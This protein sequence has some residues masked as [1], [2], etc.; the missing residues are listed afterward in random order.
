MLFRSIKTPLQHQET[1]RKKK[2]EKSPA[3]S[4]Q[5]ENQIHHP[6]NQLFHTSGILEISSFLP[7]SC[8][9]NIKNKARKLKE[10]SLTRIKKKHSALQVGRVCESDPPNCGKKIIARNKKRILK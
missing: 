5:H 9:S 7:E 1:D 6:R 2:L 4:P 8:K 3:R 10:Q